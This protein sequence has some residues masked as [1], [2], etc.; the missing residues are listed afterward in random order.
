MLFIDTTDQEVLQELGRRLREH[1]LTLNLTAETVAE[2]AG[3]SVNTVL[4]A[5]KG[6]NPTMETVV[7]LLRVMGRLDTLEGFLAS[8]TLS[9][10]DLLRRGT[11]KK[12]QRAS[13]GHGRLGHETGSS[14]G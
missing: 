2:R 7:R 4:N 3:L 12:R 1:R 8:P 11:R 5:E 14:G 9:P 13:G 6:K 10:M